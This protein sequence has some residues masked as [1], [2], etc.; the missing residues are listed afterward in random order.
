MQRLRLSRDLSLNRLRLLSLGDSNWIVAKIDSLLLLLLVLNL[1]SPHVEQVLELLDIVVFLLV[2]E[3]EVFAHV[4]DVLVPG[5]VARANTSS[6]VT[7]VK[8]S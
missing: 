7:E 2:D 4:H 8:A 3:L 1:G 5:L 6:W